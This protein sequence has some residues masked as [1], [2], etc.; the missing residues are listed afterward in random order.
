MTPA[1]PP[2]PPQDDAPAATDMP[3]LTV[4]QWI[5]VTHNKAA[6]AGAPV[7][8]SARTPPAGPPPSPQLSPP[9]AK[10]T[11]AG[12]RIESNIMHIPLDK[13]FAWGG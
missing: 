2:Q 4:D 10:Q 1:Q 8:A 6:S 5:R 7:V 12:T 13:S 3:T 9:P 11:T